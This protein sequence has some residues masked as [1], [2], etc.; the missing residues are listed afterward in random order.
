MK[1]KTLLLLVL[2]FFIT[3]IF[4]QK[5]SKK[6]KNVTGYAITAAEKGQRDWNQVR[7]IDLSTGQELKT[8]YSSSQEIEALNA[9][10]HKPVV[11]K[12]IDNNIATARKV[13]NLDNELNRADFI[14]VASRSK[15]VETDQPFATNSAAMAYDKKHDRLYYTPMGINQL[16]Y[17]DLKAK[18]PK[19]YYFEDESFGAMSSRNDVSNQITRMVIA[20]DGN[21]YALSNNCEH[22]IRFSTGKKP[23]ITDLGPLTNAPANG[24][25]SIRNQHGFTGYGGDIIADANNNL[26]L[27]TAFRNVFKIPIESKVATHLGIIKGLPNGYS[28]NGAMVEEGSKVIVASAEST[29][30]Y[31]RFDLTT[32]EAEKISTGGN[33][34]NASDLANGNLAFEKNKKEKPAEEIKEPQT[35]EITE[36]TKKNPQ[37]DLSIDKGISVYPNPVSNGTF[38]LAFNDQPIGKYNVQ[39]FDMSGKLI[40]AREI[41]VTYK[42]QIEEFRIADIIGKGNYMIKVS[43]ENDIL[44]FTQ[45]IVVQ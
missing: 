40:S 34:F 38:K 19:V 35:Q 31:Y 39:I 22:L 30:G 1:Q 36:V 42:S 27:V 20:S 28:T 26:Y 18:T 16:R 24:I 7:L 5:N 10:T 23:E 15:K 41:V 25:I 13:V 44:S 33:V 37:Q 45:K 2:T 14:R 32:L 43:N 21:G 11:K 12:D 9:R 6:E 3:C 8:I 17:I 4:A 29:S